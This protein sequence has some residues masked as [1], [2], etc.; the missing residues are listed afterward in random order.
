M[1]HPSEGTLRRL[2]DD[3][4]GVADPDREH[5]A[6]CPECLTRLAAAQR[7]AATVAAALDTGAGD[8]AGVDTGVDAAWL[9]LSGAVTTGGRGAAT[10]RTPRRRKALRSPVLAAVGVAAVLAGAGVAAAVDWLQIFRTERVAPVAVSQADVV[11]LPDLSAYGTLEV[12]AQPNVRAVAD[13]AA[14]E[15]ATGLDA[16]RV[17]ALPRGV[18]GDPRYV[19]GDRASA[20]F[21]FSADKAARAAAAVGATL[22]PPPPGLD[23]ARFR[24]DAGPGIA[25]LWSESRGMP[26]LVVARAGA[27]TASSSGVAFD[28]AREYL[29]SLPGL[30]PG[31]ASQLRRF[32]AD[33]STL[34]LPVPAGLVRTSTADVH[35]V[36]ATVLTSRD[37]AFAGV[38]WVDR[39]IVNAVAGSL[40]SD[41]V[42]AVARGLGER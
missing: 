6:R 10:S 37:R 1:R 32:S 7:D 40:S 2:V 30:P 4:A 25:A 31:V 23:G 29:L 11:E 36:P 33:A 20:V 12:T 28:V 17:R 3:P 5:V 35:G 15:N 27:P 19:V 21:T 26:A 18:T 24:L 13:A 16:P 14:A 34:P 22:P 42:L 41:E 39:G 9:R 8:G 38:V